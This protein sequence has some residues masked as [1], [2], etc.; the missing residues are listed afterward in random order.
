[1]TAAYRKSRHCDGGA[2]VEVGQGAGAVVRDTAQEA[3]RGRAELRFPAAA[4]RAFTARL[5]AGEA[6]GH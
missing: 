4:W 3:Q 5:R 2:C 1:V 6:G